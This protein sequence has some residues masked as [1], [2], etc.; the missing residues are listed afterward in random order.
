MGWRFIDTGPRPGSFNMKFDEALAKDLAQGVGC[1]AVRVYRWAPW[2][3]SLGYHQNSEEIDR[4]RCQERG[5]DIVRRPTGGRA[6]LHAEELTY[7]VV[8]PADGRSTLAIYNDI[9]NALVRGLKLFGVD[10]ALQRTQPNFAQQYRRISAVPCFTSS[11]RYEIEWRGRKLVGSAQ[12]RYAG[13]DQFVVLQHGSILCGPAHHGLI[14]LLSVQ[15][16]DTITQLKNELKEKTADLASI[17]EVPVDL[18]KLIACIRKGFEQEWGITFVDEHSPA[19]Q[20][21]M[22]TSSVRAYHG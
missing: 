9:S 12:H 16:T 7:S 20:S 11:A 22:M 4:F 19:I 8:L 2:A 21:R 6:I 13:S 18:H 14:D 5:V 15:N 10:V 3:V 17:L 1:P